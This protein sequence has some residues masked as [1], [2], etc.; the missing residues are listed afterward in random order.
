MRGKEAIR[1]DDLDTHDQAN[2]VMTGDVDIL[3]ISSK[4]THIYAPHKH[5]GF[6]FIGHRT[7]G[8]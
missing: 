3:Q 7:S 8:S 1:N 4:T 6:V 5:E 2:K